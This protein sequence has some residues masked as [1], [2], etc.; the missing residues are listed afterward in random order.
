MNVSLFQAAAAL[1]ANSRWQ[2]VIAENLAS[3]S[4]PGF[5]KQDISFSSVQSGL[6]HPGE[7]AGVVMPRA[8][9][10]TNF[11]IGALKFSGGPTDVAIEGPGFFEV[12]LPNGA[13]GFTRDGEFHINAQGQLV[14]K[15]GFAVLGE[16][17]PIQFDP[18]NSSP[19]VISATGEISQGADSKDKLK[20]LLPGDKINIQYTP[21]GGSQVSENNVTYPSRLGRDVEPTVQGQTT[22]ASGDVVHEPTLRYDRIRSATPS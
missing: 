2:E 10:A 1:N 16:N 4:I 15:Q 21:T 17:G 3:S 5:K 7:G 19:I 20:E 9:V 8:S 6:F 14:T 13:T 12:Q 22:P 11:Q 18:G